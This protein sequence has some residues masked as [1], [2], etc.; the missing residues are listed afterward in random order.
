MKKLINLPS[1]SHQLFIL[2]PK[3][4]D[5]LQVVN[6]LCDKLVRIGSQSCRK[7]L[8][9]LDAIPYRPPAKPVPCYR[10]LIGR[11]I[12]VPRQSGSI[13]SLSSLSSVHAKPFMARSR[14]YWREKEDKL[15]LLL[16]IAL[17]LNSRAAGWLDT[18]FYGCGQSMLTF[19]HQ[20]SCFNLYSNI[21]I[22]FPLQELYVYLNIQL[23]TAS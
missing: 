16:P 7:V 8:L 1:T 2:I 18:N 12:D 5:R 13:T 23:Y 14:I 6:P 21:T 22:H 20:K 10:Q 17:T 11:M 4:L 19:K 15:P 9:L 3:R